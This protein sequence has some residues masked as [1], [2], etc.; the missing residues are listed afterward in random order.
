MSLRS[1][2]F[3]RVLADTERP[4]VAYLLRLGLPLDAAGDVAQE[5]YL[6]LWQ[7]EP[8]SVDAYVVPWLYCFAR[9]R[10]I[11]RARARRVTVSDDSVVAALASE[12][13]PDRTIE[14]QQRNSALQQA[15]AQ[16][17]ARQQE[18]VGL[19]FIDGLSYRDM[20]QATGL[21]ESNVG[22]LLHQSMR[23]LRGF[24]SQQGELP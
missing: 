18:L 9:H 16:L 5:A 23:T 10:A 22:Y 2:W 19:K 8:G 1:Q 20:A 3:A 6:G 21:S 7:Q 12:D 24:L 17:P 13:R 11:D 14:H 4:L 15:I